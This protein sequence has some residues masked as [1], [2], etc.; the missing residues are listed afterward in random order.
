MGYIIYKFSKT[1]F[2]P[3]NTSTKRDKET[4]YTLVCS[5]WT[6]KEFMGSSNVPLVKIFFY[7]ISF[8]AIEMAQLSIIVALHEQMQDSFVVHPVWNQVVSSFVEIQIIVLTC[9][10]TTHSSTAQKH[11]KKHSYQQKRKRQIKQ[12]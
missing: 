4:R 1:N 7:S 9:I 6:M 8:R 3:T 10:R 2:F 12:D 11:A 5:G